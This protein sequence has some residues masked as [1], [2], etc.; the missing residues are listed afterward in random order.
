MIVAKVS[1]ATG[2]HADTINLLDY[3][4]AVFVISTSDYKSMLA[5]ELGDKAKLYTHFIDSVASITNDSIIQLDKGYCTS[6]PFY[7]R[8][9]YQKLDHA[10]MDAFQSVKMRIIKG[11]KSYN[12]SNSK[13][14]KRKTRI[15]NRPLGAVT[16]VNWVIRDAK[17]NATVTE[18][19]KSKTRH[20]YR[21]VCC[22]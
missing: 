4:G 1:F 6:L 16:G 21:M 18:L 17:S 5:K 9:D 8:E 22:F 10:L 14:T 11:G 19:N 12:F 20:A 2:Q 7:E 13:I 15:C 3:N